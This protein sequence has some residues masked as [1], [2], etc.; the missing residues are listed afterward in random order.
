HDLLHRMLLRWSS[1]GND[2]SNK[3]LNCRKQIQRAEKPGEKWPQNWM[4]PW[5]IWGNKIEQRSSCDILKIKVFG[6]WEW[7]WDWG[8]RRRENGWKERWENC[9]R[10]SFQ[11]KSRCLPPFWPGCWP[12][13]GSRQRRAVW[14]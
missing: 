2:G 8:R 6:K 9:A 13:M 7:R 11:K 10:S 14:G 4:K 3:H 1:E 5:E 12:L